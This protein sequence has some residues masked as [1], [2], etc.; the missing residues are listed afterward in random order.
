MFPR[1]ILFLV[2]LLTSCTTLGKLLNLYNGNNN[3]SYS[4]GFMTQYKTVRMLLGA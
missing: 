1:S 3:N 2:L 4:E